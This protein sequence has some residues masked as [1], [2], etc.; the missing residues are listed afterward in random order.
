M[1]YVFMWNVRGLDFSRWETVFPRSWNG[2]AFAL[3]LDQHWSM[4]APFPTREDGWF[5]LRA[6][7]SDGTEVDLLREGAPTD[8]RKPARLSSSFKDARWQKYLMNLWLQRYHTFRPAFGDWAVEDWNRRQ[9]GLSQVV[10]WEFY[11]VLEPTLDGG[12]TGPWQRVLLAKCEK[13]PGR[14]AVVTASASGSS[15]PSP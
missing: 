14:Q 11:F 3:R 7:L 2:L 1:A 6:G 8:W 13:V 12:R 5:V 4:F 9:G 15:S 10:A